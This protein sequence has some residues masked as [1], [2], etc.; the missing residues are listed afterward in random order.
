VSVRAGGA[1]KNSKIGILVDAAARKIGA[2][3]GGGSAAW[4]SSDPDKNPIISR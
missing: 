2:T 4:R 3:F 1:N